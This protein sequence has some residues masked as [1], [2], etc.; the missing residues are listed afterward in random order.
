MPYREPPQSAAPPP[1]ASI[2][3]PRGRRATI[4][5][6]IL[7]PVALGVP[8]WLW[9]GAQLA[10]HRRP[11]TFLLWTLLWAGATASWAI[12]VRTRFQR[13]VRALLESQA[14]LN[15][16]SYEAG[17]ECC[18]RILDGYR[19]YGGIEAPAL[20]NLSISVYHQGDAQRAVDMLD[21]VERAGW[22]RP[23]S[24]LRVVILQNRG[25]YQAVLGRLDEAERCA[26]EA[27]S[28]MTGARAE[29]T[30]LMLDSLLAARAGRF[31]DVVAL[32]GTSG[33][34]RRLQLRLLRLVRAWALAMTAPEAT[35]DEVRTLI[36]GAKPIAPGDLYYVAAHWPEL[37]AFLVEQGLGA[38]AEK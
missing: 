7:I 32:T 20:C 13:G 10:E 22:C 25:L 6:N 9:L 15:A 26:R 19:G 37:R 8:F 18:Q 5:L 16:G 30:L 14:L 4:A 36:D 31:A 12:Y 29:A 2:R 33:A 34:T 38:A 1:V 35:R 27:R 23:G 28:Q 11:D 17:A 21:V 24:A 3:P